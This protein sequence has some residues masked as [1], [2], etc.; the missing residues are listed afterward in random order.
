MTIEITECVCNN[1]GYN[2]IRYVNYREY[3]YCKDCGEGSFTR[4]YPKK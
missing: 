2:M 4:R 1:T 3:R